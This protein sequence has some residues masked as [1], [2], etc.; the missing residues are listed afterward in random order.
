MLG[1]EAGT[2]ILKKKS[3]AGT[4]YPLLQGNTK[5]TMP[6]LADA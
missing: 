2:V 4:A 5:L 3:W 1:Q 6:T